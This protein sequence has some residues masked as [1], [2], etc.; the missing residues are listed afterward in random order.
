MA[1]SGTPANAALPSANPGQVVTVQGSG[2]HLGTDLLWEYTDGNG[3]QA[4]QLLNPQFVNA[5]GTEAQ[6]TVPLVNNGATACIWQGPRW[7]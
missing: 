4:H 1:A 7:A 5:E 2:L 3:T 6:F